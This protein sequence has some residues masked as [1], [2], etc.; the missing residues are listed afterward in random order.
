MSEHVDELRGLYNQIEERRRLQEK[1]Y[2]D[3]RFQ[4]A[5]LVGY[6][7][8]TGAVPVETLRKVLDGERVVE[9]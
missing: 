9:L 7:K 2:D 3:L 8:R 5:F 1:L 4:L 6:H